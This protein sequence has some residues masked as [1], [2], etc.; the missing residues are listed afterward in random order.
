MVNVILLVYQDGTDYVDGVG[1]LD[2][3]GFIVQHC[4][5]SKS[6]LEQ[7]WRRLVFNILVSNTDDH[8]GNHGFILT[9]NG[10]R[11]SPA[12]DMNP[13][14][15]GNG[16]T[17]NISENSNEQDLSLAMYIAKH[18][19]LKNVDAKRIIKEMQQEISLWRSLASKADISNSEIDRMKRAFRLVDKGNF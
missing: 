15:T 9:A 12:Y 10:W 14:E 4:P 18:Y 2:L 5:A 7:L 1:Y 8:L 19:R 11:L 6:D 17:L 16:L 3:V 13:N